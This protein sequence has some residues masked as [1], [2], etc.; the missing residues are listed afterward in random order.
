MFYSQSLLSRKGPLGA[1]WIAAHC[2]KRLRKDQ[3]TG[4]NISSTVDKI[5]PDVQLS[6][7]VLAYLLLGVVR[8]F[9]KKVDYLF[10]DCNEVLSCLRK[11]IL[12]A[13]C[14]TTSKREGEQQKTNTMRL[15][16]EDFNAIPEM[17][18][19]G[20]H[21]T[22]FTVPKTFKLDAFDLDV[23]D[24]Q[25]F[26][27]P[28]I[29][30]EDEPEEF[31]F[32]N[33]RH[34]D[35]MIARSDFYSGC[36]TPGEARFD[37]FPGCST[38]AEEY[39]EDENVSKPEVSQA[40]EE[41]FLQFDGAGKR[42]CTRRSLFIR[43]HPA[44]LEDS[45]EAGG[46][47]SADLSCRSHQ[48]ERN[49]EFQTP[50]KESTGQK[51]AVSLGVR[52][53]EISVSTPGIKEHHRTSS[54]RKCLFDDTIVLSN[55]VL[56]QWIHSSNGLMSKRKKAP[57]S[58]LDIWR[59]QKFLNVEASFAEPLIPFLE[60]SDSLSVRAQR[61]TTAARKLDFGKSEGHEDP[62]FSVETRSLNGEIFQKVPC[63]AEN[64]DEELSFP[65]IESGFVNEQ[66]ESNG[67]EADGFSDRTRSIA[68]YLSQ[69]FEKDRKE[70]LPTSRI[71]QGK[72]RTKSAQMF[73]ET[74]VLKSRGC[75]DVNQENPYGEIFLSVLPAMQQ[76]FVSHS[77]LRSGEVEE[78][79]NLRKC[80]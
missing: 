7:R 66:S 56:R 17:I 47:V 33:K 49:P 42:S 12:T 37:L 48:E 21:E 32:P 20:K 10:H 67:S 65:N 76:I 75:I 30:V 52:S 9:S 78:S 70:T 26:D 50:V 68:R 5:I 77:N 72:N 71:L 39:N 19:T 31:A 69:C 28:R 60:K 15:G 29:E 59:A 13:Q 16:F 64:L 27:N 62:E 74:L 61:A 57:H 11:V 63:R 18:R 34:D 25:C 8:I 36:F 35:E 55:Q 1:I 40:F 2:Y 6:Y 38:H 41:D 24:E 79:G 3:I 45:R 46:S 4:T 44:E 53:P 51:L 22:S 73:Y 14:N 58:S 80:V 54:K 43:V 23:P